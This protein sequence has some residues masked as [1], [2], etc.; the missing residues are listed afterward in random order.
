MT[1]ADR[2]PSF[3]VFKVVPKNDGREE[4]WV[5]TISFQRYVAGTLS[6]KNTNFRI[7]VGLIDEL[8]RGTKCDSTR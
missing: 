7:Q 4:L 5:L 2:E 6:S 3:S 1:K 8:I